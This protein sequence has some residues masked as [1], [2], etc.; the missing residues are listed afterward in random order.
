MKFSLSLLLLSIMTLS[1][2]AQNIPIDFEEEGN[3]A[4][5]SWRTFENGNDPQLE[6][7]P[8]PDS[9]G[10]NVSSTVAKFTALEVGMPFAGCESLHGSDIGSFTINEDNSIIRILV[11]KSVISDVGIKLVRA[12]NWSLGE[13]KIPN[14]KVNEWEQLEFDFSSHIGNPYDQIVIFP[15][16]DSRDST[17]VIYFDDVYGDVATFTSSTQDV[18]I[19]SLK[20]F[21]NPSFNTLSLSASETIDS[22]EVYNSVG[23]L[24][25]NESVFSSEVLIDVSELESGVYFIRTFVDGEIGVRRFFKG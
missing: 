12:D 20:L 19:S 6:I 3:G 16:F 1:V 10:Y 5:W 23:Q 8:N 22:Y 17:N 2:S 11:W 13:I 18:E 25:I 24:L 9:S 7:V 21:P 15:D 4:D 14:T